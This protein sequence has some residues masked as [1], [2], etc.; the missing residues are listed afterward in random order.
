MKYSY[1]AS[2]RKKKVLKILTKLKKFEINHKNIILLAVSFFLAYFILKS[3]NV[4][5]FVAGLNNLNYLGTFVMG[6]FF[7]YGFTTAPAAATLYLMA[8]NLNPFFVAVTA[9]IGAVISDL[10]IFKFVRDR[11]LEE[12]KYIIL[13]DLHLQIPVASAILKSKILRRIIPAIAGLIMSL[14]LPGELASI[15]LGAV[16]YETKKVA[17]LSFTFNFI[18]ILNIG[19]LSSLS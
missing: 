9:A 7:S 3:E 13:E 8:K 1:L 19:L 11:L 5:A 16:R 10:I 18:G 12:I 14:P 6:M 15:L 4:A 17:L 2:E